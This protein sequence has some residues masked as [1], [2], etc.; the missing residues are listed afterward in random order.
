[1]CGAGAYHYVVEASRVG[2]GAQYFAFERAR[3][4]LA[5]GWLCGDTILG[6]A[7][8]A[9]SRLTRFYTAAEV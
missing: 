6:H 1:M 2:Y 5:C 7:F 9:R 3:G 8:S 4:L